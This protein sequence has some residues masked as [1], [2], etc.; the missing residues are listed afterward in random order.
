ML[1][2]LRAVVGDLYARAD[3]A[4]EAR[5]IFARSLQ[6]KA[7]EAGKDPSR[8]R[9]S[10][11]DVFRIGHNWQADAVAAP[12]LDSIVNRSDPKIIIR[13]TARPSRGKITDRAESFHRQ[14]EVK[15]DKA[16]GS[17]MRLI[18]HARA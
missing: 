18:Q 5:R 17:L 9:V 8:I 11:S 14:I 1:Y 3:N 12:L 15:A 10:L 4:K 6:V 7:E 2:A 13:Y 16:M